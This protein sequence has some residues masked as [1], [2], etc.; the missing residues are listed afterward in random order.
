MLCTACSAMLLLLLI[1]QPCMTHYR[2]ADLL[3]CGFKSCLRLVFT[4]LIFRCSFVT[5]SQKNPLW[6]RRWG[7]A[8]TRLASDFFRSCW[9][10][11]E[12]LP[13]AGMHHPETNPCAPQFLSLTNNCSHW[14][15]VFCLVITFSKI[16]TPW[17][18]QTKWE[19]AIGTF[20]QVRCI[21]LQTN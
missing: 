7:R 10:L 21:R 13:Q 12:F 8:S 3:C 17:E 19:K 1:M 15:F 20:L 6:E 11:R 4:S 9:P 2:V 14:T 18:W 5:L 16:S